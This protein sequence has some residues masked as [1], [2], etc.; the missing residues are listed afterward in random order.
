MTMR[1]RDVP[2][3][4]TVSIDVILSV[5]LKDRDDPIQTPVTYEIPKDVLKDEGDELS[6][7]MQ[8]CLQHILQT[9][10]T[11]REH[12]LIFS[13]RRFNKFIFLTD[14]VQG[15]SILAPDEET[16]LKALEDATDL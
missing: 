13:D 7:F 6:D 10:D 8:V 5:Y 11:V 14:E 2:E 16:I 15:I 3:E 4:S 12:R 1:P 9:I